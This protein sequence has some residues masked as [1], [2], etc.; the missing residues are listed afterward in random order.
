MNYEKHAN[1][2]KQENLHSTSKRTTKK[3]GITFIKVFFYSCLL[4]AIVGVASG[5]GIAKAI[6]DSAPPINLELASPE[7]FSTIIYDQNG[8]EV[9]TLHGEDANR[10]YVE[11][12]QI[13]EDMQNAIV[14]IEDERFWKHNGIDIQGIF[15]AI[16]SNI[17]EGDITAS[18]ASTLTQQVI[19]NN[20]LSTKKKFERKI[21]EQYLAVQ[22]EKTVSKEKILE[23][24][25]NTSHFGRGTYGVQTACKTYFNK[26]I[27]EVTLAEAAVIASITQRPTYYDPVTSP[28]NNRERQLVVLSKMLEL[29]Y[30][31]EAERDAAIAED[32]YAHIQVNSEEMAEQS[33]YSYF[34][35]EV[36]QDVIDDLMVE[37]GYTES[38]SINLVYRGGLSVYITQDQSMQSVVDGVFNDD[39]S[40]PPV[41]ESYAV[42]LMYTL[43]VQTADGVVNHYEE[44]EYDTDAQAQAHVDELKALWIGSGETIIAEKALYV[45]Q[46][47]AAMVIMDYHTGHIKAL[48]GGRGEKIGNLTF[49]R[50][51]QSKRQPGSTFKILAAYL[52]AIDTKGYTLATIIDDVPFT[53]G[54]ASGSYSPKNWYN[55]QTYNYRGLTP[56]RI[57]I[58]DSMNICAVKTLQAVG[59]DTAFD[60]LAKLGFTT[61]VDSKEIDGKIYSDKNL[62]LALGGITDGIT[63]LELN[64]AYGAIANS[65]VYMEPIFYTKVLAHDGS[66]LLDNEPTSRIVM[67]ETTAYLLTSAMTSVINSGTGRLAKFESVSMPIAGKTGTTQDDV[68]LLLSAY[69]PY[70]VATVWMGY[71]QPKKMTYSYSYHSVIWRT[72]MEQ[73]HKDLAYKEFD[74]PS[75]I[76][77]A[78]IC[79]ESG[80][81]AVSGLC[82]HD[83]RGSTIKT[84]FFAAGTVPT[85]RCDVHLKATICTT[86]GL[87]ANE[88]CPDSTTQEK[89]FIV[90]PIP[91]DSSMWDP[92]SP[93]RIADY[94]YE[95]PKS[96]EGEYCNVHGPVVIVPET[97]APET[98]LPEIDGAD[99]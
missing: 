35:D 78:S 62:A 5:L 40:F 44:S 32:V 69:T 81:L 48:S 47:Q 80:K 42:K 22:L 45:K 61:L 46:P 91:L 41:E 21:Q 90:R 86:S 38:Q 57:A 29:G 97:I 12:D 2:K 31:T 65:G 20:M 55:S 70:Y 87:F 13:P 37:K 89:I 53:V 25:L 83:P 93:P 64:A 51:T 73:I 76:V 17:K 16:F 6:I 11:L 77:S 54:S 56:V 88:Y 30:I 8:N 75:G 85:E 15:R 7:G 26:D 39:A 72:V 68:D 79:T 27:S 63:P 3:I 84:E 33:N 67:K 58:Q 36:I 23:L 98:A 59:P 50:A 92:A 94:Q 28:E 82:D 10:I 52:P 99:E 71:D 1:R 60:Y 19:K 18:G 96:M 43:S 74:V 95:L 49:N 9:Q 66:I 34:V 24:Y 4:L 14:S